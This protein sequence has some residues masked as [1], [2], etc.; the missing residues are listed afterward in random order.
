MQRYNKAI[1]IV[2]YGACFFSCFSQLPYFV[3]SG[4]TQMVCFP[5]WILAVVLLFMNCHFRI[6]KNI[7]MLFAPAST[8][9]TL[10]MLYS[11]FNPSTKYWDSSLLY[12][13]VISLFIFLVGT[14]GS[15]Y[16]DNETLN[17]IYLSYIS[18]TFIVSVAIF[19][20]YFGFSYDLSSSMY[21]YASKNSFAQI[22]LTAIVLLAVHIKP[23]KRIWLIVK[24]FVIAFEVF[25]MMYLRSR[26]TIVGFIAIVM[27]L[28]VSRNTHRALKYVVV[29]S[30]VVLI[31]LLM[32][33]N[34][35]NTIVFNNILFAGRDAN[36]LDALTSGRVTILT[37]FPELIEGHW[38]MGLGSIYYE[39][40]PLS[41]I[42]Q[43]GLFA[44]GILIIIANIPLFF[45]FRNTRLSQH[46]Y[47]LMLIAVGYFI[48][49]LF[50]GLTPFGAGIKCY[51]MWFMF[52]LLIARNEREMTEGIE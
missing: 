37:Q 21:G 36:N 9:F 28:T 45:S 23:N 2:L 7:L 22:I 14:M 40:F 42:L 1:S 31:I 3:T 43:F 12:S 50:E 44:G 15:N 49:S 16:C 35:F 8:F 33:N 39:C 30:G 32:T 10:I 34:T 17:K 24:W 27:I 51:F 38:I 47:M 29:G 25:L 13:F 18:G 26:A 6:N 4:K 11:L 46:W 52:G 5:L 20:D 48:D 19:I 41:A